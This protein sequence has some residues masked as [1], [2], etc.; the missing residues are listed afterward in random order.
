MAKSKRSTP[1]EPEHVSFASVPRDPQTL[2]AFGAMALGELEKVEEARAES[3]AKKAIERVAR[4]TKPP[5]SSKER[6]AIDCRLTD[7]A[8]NLCAIHRLT[9]TAIDST[10]NAEAVL[11]LI[12][13]T[14]RSSARAVDACLD[15]LGRGPSIGC[16]ADELDLG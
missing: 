16:F 2:A 12:R 14:A 15:K 11:L 4:R 7:V 6:D 8:H 10:A 3:G 13:E 5:L 1:S 9:V